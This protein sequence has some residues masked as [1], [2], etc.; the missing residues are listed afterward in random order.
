MVHREMNSAV[1]GLLVMGGALL[2]GGPGL[3]FLGTVAGMMRSFHA[4][5]R[6]GVTD[7]KALAS[8]VGSVFVFTAG[9]FAVGVAG[10]LILLVGVIVAMVTKK[11]PS[12]P[13]HRQQP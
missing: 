1:K 10:A 5:E 2:L 13:P 3:G 11:E 6:S 12:P 9:G 4:L 8:E 7:P